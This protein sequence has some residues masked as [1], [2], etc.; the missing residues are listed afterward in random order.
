MVLSFL[1]PMNYIFPAMAQEKTSKT[2]STPNLNLGLK[3][4]RK[5][6]KTL[7]GEPGVYRMLDE[8]GQALYVGKAKNIRKRVKSYFSGCSLRLCIFSLY[9]I[10]E[11]L[12]D[13]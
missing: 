13:S 4:L 12:N 11:A 9:F 7:S 2:T 5:T 1:L 6:L 3:I 8:K 10:V